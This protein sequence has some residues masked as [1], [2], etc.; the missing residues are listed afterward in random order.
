MNPA[1]NGDLRNRL[2][3]YM[4]EMRKFRVLKSQICETAASFLDFKLE[5]WGLMHTVSH[6]IV[7]ILKFV[8]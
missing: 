8:L 4:A 1:S 5:F 7:L 3:M 2:C 6:D